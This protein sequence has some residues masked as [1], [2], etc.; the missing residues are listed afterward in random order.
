MPGSVDLKKRMAA[1]DRGARTLNDLLDAP[2]EATPDRIALKSR[3]LSGDS[4]ITYGEL[5]TIVSRMGAG[6]I[7]LGLEKGDRVALLSENRPEWALAYA[8]VVSAGGVIV[9]LD[10]LLTAHECLRLLRHSEAKFLFISPALRHEKMEG[11]EPES[12]QTILIDD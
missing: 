3:G 6:L 8:S 4:S 12:V 11:A 7:S 1:L 5:G 9:P 10:P 2:I